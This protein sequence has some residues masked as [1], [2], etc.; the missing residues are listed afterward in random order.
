MSV[1]SAS[2]SIII[3]APYA[4]SVPL[5][6]KTWPKW[7]RVLSL[8]LASTK[9]TLFYFEAWS[10]SEKHLQTPKSPEP[11][12]PCCYLFSSI[13]QSTYSPPAAPLAP[14]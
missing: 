14:D 2:L 7:L 12:R 1:S 11:P 10:H 3:S 13:L 5:Y 4:A 9:L 6:L 8:A